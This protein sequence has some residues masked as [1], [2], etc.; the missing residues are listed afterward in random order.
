MP[1]LIGVRTRARRNAG[2]GSEFERQAPIALLQFAAVVDRPAQGV[3]HAPLPLVVRPEGETLGA[4]RSRSDRGIATRIERLQGDGDV[5]DPHDFADLRAIADIEPHA[6][7]QPHEPRQPRDAIVRG[8][9]LR[10]RAADAGFG[11]RAVALRQQRSEPLERVGRSVAGL[12][13]RLHCANRVHAA[14]PSVLMASVTEFSVWLTSLV[15]PSKARVTAMSFVISCNGLT[16]ALSM[17]PWTTPF[18]VKSRTG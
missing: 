4:I 13:G 14:P 2:G 7:A 16:L 1:V 15:T 5:F 18:C 8:R 17:V 12:G 10:H 3:D 6:F 11:E 9:D